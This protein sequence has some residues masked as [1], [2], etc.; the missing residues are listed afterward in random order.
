[1]ISHMSSKVWDEIIHTFPNFNGCTIEVLEW[2]HNLIQHISMDVIDRSMLV[3]GAPLH[4]LVWAYITIT[5]EFW[6]G[7]RDN[8]GSV[9]NKLER[10]QSYLIIEFLNE[11]LMI[12][13]GYFTLLKSNGRLMDTINKRQE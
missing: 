7:H 8:M 6:P 5:T 11:K 10:S 13:D 12:A 1:M 3:R 2:I 4:Q 9:S